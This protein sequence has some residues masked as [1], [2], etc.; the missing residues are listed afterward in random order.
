MDSY[1][2]MQNIN[3]LFQMKILKKGI[4]SFLTTKLFEKKSIEFHSREILDFKQRIK[5]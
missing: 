3:S 4:L 2:I 1:K 5:V